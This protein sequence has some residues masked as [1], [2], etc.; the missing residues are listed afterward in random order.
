MIIVNNDNIALLIITT[1]TLTHEQ[2]KKIGISADVNFKL[3]AMVRNIHVAPTL[4][5]VLRCFETY[6]KK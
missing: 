4:V 2:M 1:I 6:Q 5:V 3:Y